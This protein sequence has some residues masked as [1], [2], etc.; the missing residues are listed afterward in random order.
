MTTDDSSASPFHPALTR[1]LLKK[2]EK[3]PR[4]TNEA[5]MAAGELLRLFV[6]EARHRASIEAEC[7]T[8]GAGDD[9]VVIQP[10]HITK[11]AAELLMDFS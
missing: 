10:H 2:G 8:E 3:P 5:L 1:Q 11:V 6:A 9:T 4:I 7:E